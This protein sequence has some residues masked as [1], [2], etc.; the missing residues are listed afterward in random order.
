VY[1]YLRRASPPG[2]RSP[3]RSGQILRP[4]TSYVIQRWREGC[5][6]SMQLWRELRAQGYAYSSRTVS[7]FVTR[8]RRASEAGW[9]PETQASPYTR[10]QGPSA[11]AVSFTWVCPAVKRTPD[12][13][14]YVDQLTTQITFQTASKTVFC[15]GAPPSRHTARQ[16]T[17]VGDGAQR[18]IHRPPCAARCARSHSL[19]RVRNTTV[20]SDSI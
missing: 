4:Y 19:K 5:T 3:Q 16:N 20:H 10:P 6:D 1:A 15:S 17:R 7:R 2:P 18:D 11:R 9:A 8:L 13:Q 12:A 14:L